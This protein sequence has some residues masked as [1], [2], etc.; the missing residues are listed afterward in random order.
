M[1]M[2]GVVAGTA[3]RW[4]V[5]PPTALEAVW[6]AAHDIA[7]HT[8][9]PEVRGVLLAITES[10]ASDEERVTALGF[11]IRGLRARGEF[12]TGVMAERLDILRMFAARAGRDH[13]HRVVVQ[14]GGEEGADR[15][16]GTARPR[17][18]E[19]GAPMWWGESDRRVVGP[20]ES[21]AVLAERMAARACGVPDPYAGQ[22]PARA[23]AMAVGGA[24]R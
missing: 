22:A 23:E 24:R 2:A 15:V 7:R 12:R 14:G 17:P 1:V 6:R 8:I 18:W 16:V 5:E 10:T 9:V 19:G 21:L 20:E 11:V 4:R 3:I 13:E